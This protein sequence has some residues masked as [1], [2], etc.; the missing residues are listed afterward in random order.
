MGMRS[1]VAKKTHITGQNEI[2]FDENVLF[3]RVLG[4]GHR[5]DQEVA[6][7]PRCARHKAKE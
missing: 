5:V 4:I 2:H 3:E 7:R 1:A 6:M